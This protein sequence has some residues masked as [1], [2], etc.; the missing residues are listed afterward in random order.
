MFALSR[1][2]GSEFYIFVISLILVTTF[3]PYTYVFGNTFPNTPHGR[4]INTKTIDNDNHKKMTKN[5]SDGIFRG[6]QSKM[7]ITLEEASALYGDFIMETK[8]NKHTLKFHSV[9]HDPATRTHRYRR[10][11]YYGKTGW[12][13]Y[14]G[15][16]DAI[17]QEI[18][19]VMT[20]D[21]TDRI[22]DVSLKI[23]LTQAISQEKAEAIA[24]SQ[25][26][27]DECVINK[28]STREV[29][30]PY[31]IF[32]SYAIDE[33]VLVYQIIITVFHKR[34]AV[35]QNQFFI[36]QNDGSIIWQTDDARHASG[37]SLYSG[38]VTIQ[39]YYDSPFNYME[40]HTLNAGVYDCANGDCSLPF[41]MFDADD[42]WIS[43]SQHAAVDVTYG[44]ALVNDYLAD[45]LGRD[46]IDGAGGPQTVMS[47]D[48]STALL[49]HYIHYGSGVNAATWTG[50]SIMYGDGD[51]T[52][53]GPLVSMDIVAHEMMHGIV[54]YTADFVYYGESGALEESFA[55]IL[56]VAVDIYYL[57]ERANQ[58]WWFSE[59]SWT[60]LVS[61]DA[62]R[63]LDDPHMAADN[64][65]TANDDPDHVSEMYTGS[66]DNGGVH[67]NNGIPNKAFYLATKGGV[68]HMFPNI[69]VVGVGIDKTMAIWYRAL[70]LYLSSSSDFADARTQTARAARDLYGNGN[71]SEAV[72]T[73]WAVCGVGSL[74]NQFITNI[75]Q[76][77]GFDNTA[78]SPWYFSG[79]ST[80]VSR[81]TYYYQGT[82]YACGGGANSVTGNFYQTVYLPPFTASANV[83]FYLKISTSE[84]NTQIKDTIS[85][86][87]RDTSGNYLGTAATFSNMDVGTGGY[88]LKGPFDIKSYKSY[89]NVRLNFVVATSP[90]LISSF[91]VDVVTLNLGYF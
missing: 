52:T 13:V 19:G 51:G 90:S 29:I 8:N 25:I 62:L 57:G 89:G 68:H 49:P 53:S 73:A 79:A 27:C 33:A 24:L 63:Y 60:P 35:S 86:E 4:L 67:H 87:V 74:P 43:S 66:S 42:N 48:G 56:A 32:N 34:S 16:F 69:T 15:G 40:D 46:G 14:G 22:N 77:G 11:Q 17:Y 38:T 75:I 44:Q 50:D 58:S 39:S 31:N 76:N 47:V 59:D 3:S 54:E 71:E 61:G 6:D 78:S 1:V 70:N 55:D 18:D 20:H 91:Y 72:D 83:S 10:D 36:S 37:S 30:L 64:G 26:S 12:R 9:A 80:Y 41:Q 82:G 45:M 5:P 85:L 81:G 65:F 21:H 84:S 2:L 7:D 28:V 23:D 88:V